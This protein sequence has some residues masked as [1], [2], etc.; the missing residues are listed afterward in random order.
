MRKHKYM[1]EKAEF[2]RAGC[3]FM[4][5]KTIKVTKEM[6]W[7]CYKDSREEEYS[8]REMDILSLGLRIGIATQLR[9]EFFLSS[10]N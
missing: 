2:M 3:G 1:N 4:S 5:F 10:R 6:C 8:M 7:C 9:E